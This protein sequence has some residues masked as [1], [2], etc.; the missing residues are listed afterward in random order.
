MGDRSVPHAR[1]N[2]AEVFARLRE[3]HAR[4]VTEDYVEMIA[5]LIEEEGEAR[6]V[7]LAERFGVTAATVNNTIKR[8]ERDGFVTSRP[9]RSVFLTD[10]GRELAAKCRKRHEIVYNFLVAL[11]VDP[12]TAEFDAEG[13]EH[14]VSEETLKMFAGFAGGKRG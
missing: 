5:D 13:I 2:K 12:T 3:A 11:G 14:H 7:A 1:P 9:Y 6:S 4:E 10:E 8:L